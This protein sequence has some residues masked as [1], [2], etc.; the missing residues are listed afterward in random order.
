LP[1]TTA[2]LARA[3]TLFILGSYDLARH[4]ASHGS[5]P[6]RIVVNVGGYGMR[7]NL[8]A[9]LHSWHEVSRRFP[10][11]QLVC[12]GGDVAPGDHDLPP[13]AHVRGPVSE[14]MLRALLD[15]A[16]VFVYPSLGEGFGYPPLEAMRHGACVVA[17][18]LPIFQETLG[19]AAVLVPPVADHLAQAIIRLLEDDGL[20]Q[21]YMALGMTH[22]RKYRW[23]SCWNRHLALYRHLLGF[24]ARHQSDGGL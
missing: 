7:K 5:L 21:R 10:D 2:F 19:E 3:Y 6:R 13:N 22:V 20:R 15:R 1:D 24:T 18:N 17:T 14:A 23:E 9:L 11:A 12:V 4:A 8:G 16:T